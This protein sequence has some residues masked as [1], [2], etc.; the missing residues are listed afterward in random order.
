M[1]KL[2]FASALV[3]SLAATAATETA[4]PAEDVRAFQIT[5]A[6]PPVPA[7]KYELLFR[8]FS[9]RLPG[10]AAP[11]YLDALLYMRPKDTD[12]FSAALDAFK[13]HD[14]K[15][16]EELAPNIAERTTTFGQLELAGRRD[17][18]DW[19]IPYRER[20]AG[21][22][23]AH[24]APLRD[25]GRMLAVGALW[26]IQH[27]QIDTALRTL[28]VGYA[29]SYKL[30]NEPTLV[31]QLVALH[32]E[33]AL[34]D[35]AAE[36]MNRADAPNLY[37][38]L[39]DL[40]ARKPSFRID[41]D[42]FGDAAYTIAHVTNLR[43]GQEPSAAQWRDV[44]TALEKM[45]DQDSKDFHV[46]DVVTKTSAEIAQR[47]RRDFAASHHLNDDQMA[48]LDPLEPLCWYYFDQYR[49]AYDDMYKLQGLAYPTMLANTLEYGIK[50]DGLKKAQPA[51]PFL[52][53]LPTV[54]KAVVTFAKLDRQ[55]AALTVV[56]AIRSYAAEHAG[57][58]PAKLDEITETP[59]SIN[60]A[61]GKAFEYR[62]ENGKVTLEDANA[63]MPMKYKITIRK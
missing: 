49:I 26:Q 47:A 28:R 31:S 1:K 13:A 39:T 11:L 55:V 27:D 42:H 22:L 25:M 34:N 21:T 35:A 3:L 45:Y 53:W 46:D 9:D 6:A 58:L 24:L 56:E 61:T 4:K 62:V 50:M 17:H 14:L 20:G 15:R 29:L 10:N 33:F 16:F 52:K 5:P 38:A 60:P 12:D 51:N 44:L 32:I 7:M 48:K 23:L 54:H 43:P 41:F 63:E 36:L 37:W 18:C 30:S 8:D 57:M 19:D 2:I 59:A 40:P